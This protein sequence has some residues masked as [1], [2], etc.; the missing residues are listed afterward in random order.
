MADCQ[1]VARNATE[2]DVLRQDAKHA[3]EAHN[4][5]EVTPELAPRVKSKVR[6]E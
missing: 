5:K 2:D 6:T 1:H 3:A 4:I